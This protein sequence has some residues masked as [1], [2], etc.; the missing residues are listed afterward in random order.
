MHVKILNGMKKL[1]VGLY[2]VQPDIA[3]EWLPPA[4]HI[5]GLSSNLGPEVTYPK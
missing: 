5:G 1:R 2:D 3:V 4:L